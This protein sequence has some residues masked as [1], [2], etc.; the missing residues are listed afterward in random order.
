MKYVALVIILLLILGGAGY[1]F[2]HNQKSASVTSTPTPTS[3][4]TQTS[5]TTP[6]TQPSPSSS[7]SAY[8][9]PSQLQAS[10]ESGAAA[11]N[12]YVTLTIKNTSKTSCQVIGN[13][14]V[15][16]DYPLSVTNF[17]TV[18]KRQPTTAVFTLAPNQTIYSLIHF[19]NGPQCSSRATDVDTGV[20]YAISANDA[21]SFKPTTGT[22]LQI[23]SCGSASD[24]T[25]ID[26]YPF[27]TQ[28]VTP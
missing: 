28:Q 27:S 14:P 2:L 5:Q 10:M 19:P 18:V 24:I 22:T 9:M 21:V 3:A 6:T 25:T 26:L 1:L 23:P 13:N 20:S 7:A 16:V 4:P 15:K 11:G 17:K 8:C 12:I